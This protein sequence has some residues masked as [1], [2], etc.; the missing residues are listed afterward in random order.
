MY[1]NTKSREMIRYGYTVH[2]NVRSSPKANTRTQ[3]TIQ[4]RHLYH[5]FFEPHIA[6]FRKNWDNLSNGVC[7]I[8]PQDQ[9]RVSP[10]IK[11]Q[12]KPE[13]EKNIVEKYAHRS[14]AACAKVC[15][16]EGLDISDA[17]FSSLGTE[18]ERG[19]FVREK[20]NEKAKSNT[21]FKLNRRCFQW[22]YDRGV[23]CTSSTFSLGGPTEGA[24]DDVN[25]VV[26][27]GWFVQ[28]IN[29]W[30]DT[31]GNCALDWKNPTTPH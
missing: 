14:A 20:Y 27:S 15:E 30:V 28:G 22:K 8:S 24:K 18:M 21:L 11:S 17:E 1:G 5:Q 3:S 16:A 29:D 23:C 19:K 13:S 6:Y 9:N 7:Y 4:Y 31:M 2:T 25:D 10:S 12:Q 26:T